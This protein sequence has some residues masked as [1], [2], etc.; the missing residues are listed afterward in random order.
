LERHR[1]DITVI[2]INNSGQVAGYGCVRATTRISTGSMRRSRGPSRTTAWQSVPN[3]S[4]RMPSLW[5]PPAASTSLTTR[6]VASARSRTELSPPS[7]ET[8]PSLTVGTTARRKRRAQRPGRRRLRGLHYPCAS[9]P[10]ITEVHVNYA[11]GPFV[12]L[13]KR[14]AE[15]A[16]SVPVVYKRRPVAN[17]AALTSTV[18]SLR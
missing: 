11:V 8:G 9:C 10:R 6:T 3:C 12:W 14:I 7:Q 16:N 13:A 5:T 4:C 18:A 17:I 2:G 15:T 1:G